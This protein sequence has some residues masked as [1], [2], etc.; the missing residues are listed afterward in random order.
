M[1][2]GEGRRLALLVGNG[3]YKDGSVT[4]L[5]KPA[6]DVR[7]LARVLK[8]PEIGGF[9]DVR[10]L[11]DKDL[12][13]V[14]EAIELFFRGRIDKDLLLLYYSGHGLRKGDQLYLAMADTKGDLPSSTAL[15]SRWLHNEVE[16]SWSSGRSCPR[17]CNSGLFKRGAKGD[18][19]PVLDFAEGLK[20][21]GVLEEGFGHFVLSA[22]S[23]DQKAWEGRR[24]T[25]PSIF[26]SFLVHGLSTGEA[27]LNHDGRIS[28][29]DL[30]TYVSERVSRGG[31]SA[32]DIHPGTDRNCSC[33]HRSRGCSQSGSS[34]A[35]PVRRRAGSSGRRDPGEELR[36]QDF[37]DASHGRRSQRHLARCSVAGR[38]SPLLLP[39]RPLLEAANLRGAS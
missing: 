39:G 9:D 36:G 2:K 11:I 21:E 17:R 37:R 3:T 26:T 35:E 38:A 31:R 10:I 19:L 14:H 22:A 32:G 8:Q 7:E 34:A 25:G 5:Q 13:E 1:S 15:W 23:L 28:V 4:R 6:V 16:N 33:R 20:R 24:G 18:A 30:F 27:D 12:N 29:G